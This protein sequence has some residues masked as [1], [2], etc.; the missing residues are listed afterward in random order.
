MQDGGQHA[1]GVAVHQ[2]VKTGLVLHPY[3]LVKYQVWFQTNIS[4]LLD[5]VHFSEVITERGVTIPREK[6]VKLFNC[7]MI[8]KI[9]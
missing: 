1:A 5:R 8:C 3:Q 9:T 2:V 7:L 4:C 6:T